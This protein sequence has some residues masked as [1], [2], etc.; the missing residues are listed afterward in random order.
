MRYSRIGIII[1][2]LVTGWY[3]FSLR[4]LESRYEAMTIRYEKMQIR[5]NEMAKFMDERLRELEND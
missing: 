2:I 4:N 5:V 1:A 3:Y